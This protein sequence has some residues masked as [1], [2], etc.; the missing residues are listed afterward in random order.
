M[1]APTDFAHMLHEPNSV[2]KIFS[3]HREAALVLLEHAPPDPVHLLQILHALEQP[4][5]LAEGD[6]AVGGAR[7]HARELHQLRLRCLVDAVRARR[8]R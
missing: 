4:M 3:L 1:F 2:E 6:D 7:A 5:G 8:G